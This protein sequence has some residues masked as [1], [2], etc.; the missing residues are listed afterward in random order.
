MAYSVYKHTCP[1]GKVYIGI[2]KLALFDRWRLGEAYLS[3][4]YFN[5]AILEHGW[6][7][8]THEIVAQGLSREDAEELEINLIKW[9][10]ATDRRFGYNISP[11]ARL[12]ADET[13]N[14]LRAANTGKRHTQ[15]TKK[16]LSELRTGTKAD[17]TTQKKMSA[18]RKG[19][20]KATAHRERLSQ[21]K[22]FGGIVCIETGER[23]SS[24]NEAS[25][26]TGIGKTQI[27]DCLNGKRDTTGGLHWR[28]ERG[29]S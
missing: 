6:D 20:P 25:R 23:Y 7:A 26:L 10:N 5:A 29:N 2:T 12:V 3:N 21:A 9:H 28:C 11:G 14:K 13:R 18:Q 8:F 19:V 16:V 1:N 22:G 24:R 27:S 17:I 15:E 4:D